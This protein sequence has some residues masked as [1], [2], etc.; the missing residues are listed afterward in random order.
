MLGALVADAKM[1]GEFD[2]SETLLI[3][4]VSTLM[5]QYNLDRLGSVTST[6]LNESHQT[7]KVTMLLDGERAPIDLEFRHEKMREDRID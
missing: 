1:A 7:L 6:D 2:G 5:R 3:T 4:I